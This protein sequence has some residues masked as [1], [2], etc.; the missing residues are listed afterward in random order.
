MGIFDSSDQNF[1]SREEGE[2]DYSSDAARVANEGSQA[3][4]RIDQIEKKVN[5]PRLKDARK[6]L[7]VANTLGSEE[8][9]SEK[10]QEASPGGLSG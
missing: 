1:Y 3:R 6:K 10:V 5:D 4:S 8:T 2:R 9:D 7:E